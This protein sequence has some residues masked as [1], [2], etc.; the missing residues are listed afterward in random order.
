MGRRNAKRCKGRK[1]ISNGPGRPSGQYL[2]GGRARRNDSGGV[3]TAPAP[4]S[5]TCDLADD[6]RPGVDRHIRKRREHACRRSRDTAGS[7]KRSV[8]VSAKMAAVLSAADTNMLASSPTSLSANSDAS[9]TGCRVSACP[10][11]SKARAPGASGPCVSRKRRRSLASA[12]IDAG[13]ARRR[14]SRLRRAR[15]PR[16]RPVAESLH[17]AAPRDA[18]MRWPN[19]GTWPAR[20]ALHAFQPALLEA[21]DAHGVALASRQLELARGQ[22]G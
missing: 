19:D 10:T 6:H 16:C 14:T 5:T 13:G 7:R 20:N 15:S 12:A 22:P 4:A 17:P 1:Y 9:N 11:I 18:G 3:A 21:S 2:S 8:A